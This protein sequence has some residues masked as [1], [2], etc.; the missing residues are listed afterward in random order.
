MVKAPL[1]DNKT[2]GDKLILERFRLTYETNKLLMLTCNDSGRLT[3]LIHDNH[4]FI[5]CPDYDLWMQAE[6]LRL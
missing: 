1:L 5:E 3:N 2:K 4:N 6:I